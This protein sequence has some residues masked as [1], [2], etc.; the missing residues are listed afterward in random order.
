MAADSL[1]Q[2]HFVNQRVLPASIQQPIDDFY[3]SMFDS[4]GIVV[5]YRKGSPRKQECELLARLILQL[6]PERTLDWGLGA[7]AVCMVIALARR[8][9]GISGQHISLDPCQHSWA[10]DV[11]LIQLQSRGLRDDVDFREDRSDEFLVEAAKSNRTFDFIFV[12][13]HHGFG[14]K[15]ADAHLADR[16]LSPGGVIAFHDALLESTA[17]AVSLLIRDPPYRYWPLDLS[18]QPTW[19]IAGRCI[20]HAPRLGIRYACKVTPRLGMSIA[21]LRKPCGG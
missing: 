3:S 6:K 16:V 11:G 15:V 17:T 18:F 9:L 5:R 19:K 4:E 8:E 21:A 14:Y 20:R 10:K 2:R 1:M 12:D 13:G 7:G